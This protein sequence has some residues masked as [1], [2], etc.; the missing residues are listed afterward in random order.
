M[1]IVKYAG[2]P[3]LKPSEKNQWENLCVLNPGV[4]YDDKTGKFV[5]LYRAAGDDWEHWIR[6]GLAVSDDGLH[7]E[8]CSDEPAMDG[9]HETCEASIEDP[10]IVKIDG[11]Y[12]I[13][14]A[15]TSFCPGRY[16]NVEEWRKARAQRDYQPESAPVIVN[17]GYSVSYL[18]YTD[19]FSRF[20]RLGRITDSRYDDRD[21]VLFPEKVG[22]KFV[23]ISR[24]KRDDK[25]P[26]VWIT[27]SDDLMEWGEPTKLFSGVEEWEA[28]RIGAGCPPIR[29]EDGW[30]LIYHGV[31]GKDHFYRVGMLLLDLNDP[32][33]ILAR[34][35]DYVM[36]PEFDYEV[37]GL[38]T[39][40][41]FPT[42]IVEKDGLLYIYYGCADRYVSA[43]TVPLADVLEHMKKCRIPEAGGLQ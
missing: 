31:S 27:F 21:V 23:K 15:A 40:C 42:G 17:P 24:P 36:E 25:A 33:K 1:K 35:K 11:R 30:L 12:Y 2:N 39:G 7:F 34:T 5:M 20:K 28:E 16:W 37:N 13:T 8:R 3:I 4:V 19:D 43:A 18:A 6:L 10:R 38:W 9:I 29:T 32:R 41:V 22:G 14:Y 26:A